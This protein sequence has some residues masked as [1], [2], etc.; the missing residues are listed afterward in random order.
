MDKVAAI[1]ELPRPHS[2]KSMKGFL[3]V[4]E[5]YRKYIR[6]YAALCA[7]LQLMMRRNVPYVCTDAAVAAFDAVK[8]ALCS[9]PV[10]ALLDWS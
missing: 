10:L 4:M 3:G 9:A 8:Q 6:D 5:Q 7:P 1:M 2:V